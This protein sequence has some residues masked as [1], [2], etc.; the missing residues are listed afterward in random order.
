MLFQSKSEK[1][2]FIKKCDEIEKCWSWNFYFNLAFIITKKSRWNQLYGMPVLD[3]YFNFFCC[4]SY[5][6]MARHACYILL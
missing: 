2:Q 4:S 5:E 3:N 6:I 1:D